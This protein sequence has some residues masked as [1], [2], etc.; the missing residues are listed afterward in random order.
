VFFYR[1]VSLVRLSCF[2]AALL[3]GFWGWSLLYPEPHH[4][5]NNLFRTF[6]LLTLQ[7]S[8]GPNPALEGLNWQ[9]NLARILVPAFALL[10]SYRLVMIA[11]RNPT[12]LAMLAL[13]RG[14]TI[15]VPGRGWVGPAMLREVQTHRMR[16]LAI[17]PD[18]LAHEK[19]RMEQYELPVLR[20]DP[21]LEETWHFVRAERAG[22]IVVSHGSD[23]ENLNILVTVADAIG[24]RRT[25]NGPM[26]VAT[27]ENENFA[28]QVDVALDHAAHA[29]G[30]QYRRLSV[31]NECARTVF[32]D[33][34]LPVAK[35][36]RQQPSHFVVVGLGYGARAVLSHALTLGQDCAAAGPRITILA[37]DK[38]L[39]GEPLLRPDAVP[40]YVATLRG[41]P[42][43]VAR[44]I[45]DA[46]LLSVLDDAPMPVMACVCLTDEA[47]ATVGMALARQVAVLEWPHFP[48]AVHQGREDR[49][50]RLL[51]RENTIKGHARLRPFGGVLPAGALRRLQTGADE[52][53]ARAIHEHYL[54]TLRNMKDVGGT[55]TPW[56]RLPENLRHA[57]R[58]AA[59]HMAVKLAAIGCRV[60]TRN[61]EP[62]AFT[63]SEIDTLAQVE[64]RRWSAERLL[65][66]WRLGERDNDR[67]KH[68]DLV[69]YE[70][71]T[72]DGREKDRSQVRHMPD[73]LALAGMAIKRS[74]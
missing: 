25:A 72:D 12:R 8:R 30:I 10:Q 23:S 61:A 67:R 52:K 3:L 13:R 66:G 28:E 18:L 5:L 73:I 56:D 45:S 1:W 41:I 21:F 47:A 31:S 4:L 9:V 39:A 35:S 24:K 32:L 69:P 64:H 50:L 44:G 71:L 55:P 33:P 58:A 27:L 46:T 74:E 29:S 2:I 26:L 19:E 16:A 51:A 7:T 34:P 60:V 68:P 15:L 22:L 6:Q 48:I 38:D 63:D 11:I 40:G 17:A 62:F 53:L 54:A 43:D 37:S 59:D 36:D 14:H 20:L 70:D 65:R 49:F 42:C 57:N